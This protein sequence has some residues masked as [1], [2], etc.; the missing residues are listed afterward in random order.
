MNNQ[1]IEELYRLQAS[2][3]ELLAEIAQLRRHGPSW[4]EI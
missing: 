2:E 1:R 4:V 3:Q